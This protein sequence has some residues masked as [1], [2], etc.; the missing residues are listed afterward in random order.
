MKKKHDV[1][2]YKDRVKSVQEFDSKVN[3]KE[4]A[5]NSKNYKKYKRYTCTAMLIERKNKEKEYNEKN[6][7][8]KIIGVNGDKI[9]SYYKTNKDWWK[10]RQDYVEQPA[11]TSQRQLQQDNKFWSRNDPILLADFSNEE[12]PKDAFK[13]HFKIENKKNNISEKPN[14]EK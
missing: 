6:F 4:N 8:L 7:R 5:F 13:V 2:K 12:A 11:N 10:L 14:N 3:Q 1:E 9:P